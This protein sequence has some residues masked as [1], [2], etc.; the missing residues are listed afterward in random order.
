MNKTRSFPTKEQILEFITS[1]NNTVGRREIAKAFGVKG[2]KRVHLKGLLRD[3]CEE[4]LIERGRGKSYEAT[5]GLPSVCLLKVVDINEDGELLCRP[6]ERRL[7]RHA[8]TIRLL[9]RG[10]NDKRSL[11]RIAVNDRILARL[12]KTAPES[13]DARPIKRVASRE[14][15]FVGVYKR[16]RNGRARIQPLDRNART[17]FAADL[18]DTVRPKSGDLVVADPDTTRSGSAR[19]LEVI[20]RADDPRAVSLIAIHK[21]QLPNEFAPEVEQEAKTRKRPPKDRRED[22]T[23]LPLVT[24][25]PDDAKD[26][27]DAVHAE[28]D[29]NNKGGWIVTV[30]IADVAHYVRPDTTLDTS[31]FDRGNSCYFPDR[32]VPMLPEHLSNDLCSLR[33]QE[34]RPTLAVRM[35]FDNQGKKRGHTFHRA[36]IRS[37]AR[38]TYGQAQQALVGRPEDL[39]DQT[40]QSLDNI[41]QAYRLIEEMR[42]RRGPLELDL[43]EHKISFDEHGNVSGI[44]PYER[45]EAHKLIEEFM[46]QAN[47]CAAETIEAQ[48]FPCLYRIHEPPDEDKLAGLSEFLKSLGLSLPHSQ[49]LKP[50]TFN[51]LLRQAKKADL[52]NVIAEVVLRSQSQAAYSTRSAGHF[53]LNLRRY[54][55][56]TSPIR[57]YADLIIHR[58]LIRLLNLGA[59]GLTDREVKE[60][61]SIAEHISQRERHTMAAER[62]TVDRFVSSFLEDH[63]GATFT[64]KIGGVT[65]AGLFV[66]LNDTGADGFVPMRA[67][68]EDWYEHDENRK[69]L[70][71]RNHG[72]IYRLGQPVTVKLVEATPLQGGLRFELISDPIKDKAFGEGKKKPKSRK[73]SKRGK[74]RGSRNEHSRKR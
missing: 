59:D 38:L 18:D 8:A 65:R 45:Y 14:E 33:P 44:A 54:A 3:M 60:L 70:I 20:G 49:V 71:G 74:R 40:A 55:H 39:D 7:E 4:G 27:D 30:A 15:R 57:R 72:G 10:S 35:T 17:D 28:P 12:E 26:F 52:E 41:Q 50:N 48:S 11:A 69:A 56:F 43:A 53:G 37:S 24:I 68:T 9:S 47:V 58:T 1:A 32:V 62:E 23:E 34:I 2:D 46:I 36:L 67:L 51:G 21:Y 6:A 19:I 29:P 5:N 63:V 61:D 25:D 73:S 13:Y 64:G 31:A 42:R 66:Q 22:F 16:T